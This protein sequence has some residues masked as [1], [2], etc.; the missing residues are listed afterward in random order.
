MGG[1]LMLAVVPLLW[2]A[3]G[4]VAHAATGSAPHDSGDDLGTVVLLVVVIGVA[5]VLAHNVVER[6]QR[7][8]L[9]V[10][11]VEYLL[12]GFLLGPAFPA[13]H[14]LDDVTGLLPI[15]ALAAG[16]VGLLRGTDFD[17]TSLQKLDPATWRVVF[18][19][20]LLPAVTVGFGSYYFFT[21]TGWVI[22]SP[23]D[24][25]LSSAALACFAATDSSEPF[26]LLARRY[27][28]SGRL[29]PLLRNGTRL[30]DIGVIL[31]FGLIFC[32]FHE[33]APEAQDYSPSLWAWVTVLLGAALG[34]L[35]SL[36]L[37]GDESDN[38]RFLAL[39]GIIAFAS[40]GAYFLE[41]S[42]LAVNLSMGFVLVNFARGG[43]LLH[44]TL[45]STERPMAL[46]LL[47]FAG[48]LW[49]RTE[50]VPTLLGLGGF[51]VAR[52]GAK[53]LASAIAGWGTSLRKDLFRG[54]L[55]HG[56]VTLAMA[57]SFRLVYD[58]EAAKIAY[59]VVLGSVILNGLM[60]PRLLRGLL[61]DEGEIQRE[62]KDSDSRTSFE[63][64]TR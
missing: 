55:A 61:V 25:M 11:G 41:L 19:H 46:V 36:F 27:Q 14:A 3:L 10:T 39:V 44:T 5:Y 21:E 13:I 49:E 12:L 53:W 31:A 51:L 23:R 57:V 59:S 22:V 52:T 17:F 40:G 56:N 4:G 62:L 50:L 45:V 43:Q 8:F 2:A 7:R 38:S 20:H 33:N 26:D 15:I 58:G 47:V 34:F 54:L 32:V 16:W 6:L 37:V 1:K 48:A 28:I 24:A 30:G 29:A 35:F 63:V 42:P 60:A 9:V 18:L 64:T